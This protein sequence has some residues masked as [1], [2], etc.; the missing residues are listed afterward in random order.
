MAHEVNMTQTNC[1]AGVRFAYLLI[2]FGSR[3]VVV[4][5]KDGRGKFKSYF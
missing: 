4:F 3:D 2:F 5:V 1:N